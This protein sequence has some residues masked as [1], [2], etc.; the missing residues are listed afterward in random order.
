M[1]SRLERAL[2]VAAAGIAA[3]LLPSPERERLQREHDISPPRWSFAI[4]LLEL[5]GG[6]WLFLAGALAYVAGQSTMLSLG[7]LSHWQPGLSTT[8]FRGAG[9]I[10]FLFWLLQPAAWLYAFVATVGLVRVVAFTATREAVGEPVVVV[11]LRMLQHS[12]RRRA[13]RRRERELGPI[14]P[15]RIERDDAGRLVVV[16]CREKPDWRDEVTIEIEGRFHRLVAVEERPHGDGLELAYVLAEVDESE[17]I[18]R[19]I[20]Y[21]PPRAER[22]GEAPVRRPPAPEG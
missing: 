15:D 4:G 1:R 6:T 18:R 12:R 9:L 16:S 8:H 19:L 7:L 5:I 20:R 3:A 21:A 10:A 11:A 22:A 13:A 17:L 2:R 14:R